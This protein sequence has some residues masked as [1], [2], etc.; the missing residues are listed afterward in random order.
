MNGIFPF[1]PLLLI[2]S[3]VKKL[4]QKEAKKKQ[5]RKKVAE[6]E[7]KEELEPSRLR[8]SITGI[9]SG[10]LLLMKIFSFHKIGIICMMYNICTK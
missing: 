6:G 1:K 5:K 4:E 8:L 9:I 2:T 10:L 3:A 7:K